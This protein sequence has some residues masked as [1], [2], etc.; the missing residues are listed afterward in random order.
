MAIVREH[1]GAHPA[2][3]FR[4]ALTGADRTFSRPP[5]R[6]N[7][8]RKGQP[9]TLT[10]AIRAAG[11]GENGWLS[12]EVRRPKAIGESEP[13]PTVITLSGTAHAN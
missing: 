8:S 9:L 13:M 7:A 3:A 11:V 6:E 10:N 2:A 12:G 4:E 1:Q 5:C